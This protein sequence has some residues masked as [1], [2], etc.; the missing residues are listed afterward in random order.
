MEL[1]NE[2]SATCLVTLQKPIRTT[3]IL[4]V[5]T[6]I[7]IIEL[8]A[9]F[10]EHVYLSTFLLLLFSQHECFVFAQVNCYHDNLSILHRYE[11]QLENFCKF[12]DPLFDSPPPETSQE[13][14]SF[15][16]RMRDK[17]HRSVFW[18]HCLRRALDLGQNEMV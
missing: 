2:C 5:L 16:D 12:M 11:N 10:N 9:I 3:C 1:K 18:A 4:E 17:S 14:S 13:K 15:S 6:L 8:T 7:Y